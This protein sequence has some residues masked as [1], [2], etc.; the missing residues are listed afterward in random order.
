M[1]L[2]ERQ[3]AILDFLKAHKTATIE[4]LSKALYVSGATIRRDISVLKK[5]GLLEKTYGGVAVIDTANEMPI[6][7]RYERETQ[8]KQKVADIAYNHLPPFKTVFIDNSSTTLIL[9]RKLNLR[10][11]TVVT[12]GLVV[13]QELSRQDDIDILLPGGS[14]LYNANSIVGAF[15]LRCLSDMHYDLMLCSCAA[16]KEDGA[17]ENSLDQ[18]E[19]KRAALRNSA[20]KVLLVDQTK[21][22]MDGMFKSFSLNE[23]DIIFTNADSTK[24]SAFRNLDVKIFNGKKT[25]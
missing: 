17:Y 20:K 2:S 7:V 5:L 3:N 21:F 10:Y 8:E 9:A 14:L 4:Q 13:A 25:T 24:L 18:S 1:S 19:L 11:K 16:I 22:D 23:F 15:T 12:N 6:S